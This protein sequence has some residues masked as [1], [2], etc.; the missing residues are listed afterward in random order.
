MKVMMLAALMGLATL[1]L[2]A[3]VV[4]NEFNGGVGFYNPC[5]GLLVTA[6]GPVNLQVQ[7]MENANKVMVSIHGRI[8]LEGTDS[9]GNAYQTS[10]QMN[11]NFDAK[12]TQYVV[13][14]NAIFVGQGGASNFK[15]DGEIRIFVNAAG[16]P[17]GALIISATTSC[18]N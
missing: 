18:Q 15:A 17:V 4:Q 8:K 9:Q 16:K 1:G 2:N 7:T 3:E 11:A 14:Y 6:T 13:P 10:F 5:N 12:S